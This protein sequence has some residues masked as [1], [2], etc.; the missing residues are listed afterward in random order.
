VKV[1]PD[2]DRARTFPVAEDFAKLHNL[3]HRYLMKVEGYGFDQK[4]A[5]HY[6]VCEFIDG[7]PLSQMVREKG[8]EHTK[9]LRWMEQLAEALEYLHAQDLIHFDVKP[10]NV[11]VNRR[12]LVLVDF[13]VAAHRD[14]VWENWR[15]GT[16]LYMSPEHRELF[17]GKQKPD[18][19]S[20]VWS[21]GVIMYQLL[22]GRLP[23]K[24]ED[25]IGNTAPT[26]VEELK[27][28]VPAPV[29]KI[30][31]GCL[32]RDVE[33][34][35]T[36][37][38]LR[39]AISKRLRPKQILMV[40][41]WTT[42]FT[43][44]LA[45]LSWGFVYWYWV[46]P[47]EERTVDGLPATIKNRQWLVFQ[48]SPDQPVDVTDTV[49]INPGGRLR[50]KGHGKLR[51][52]RGA[53]IH[54]QG[55][56]ELE[57][58]SKEAPLLFQRLNPQEEWAGVRLVGEHAAGSSLRNARFE[59]GGGVLCNVGD[60]RLAGRPN[61]PQISFPESPDERT[62]SH[63]GALLI[64]QTYDIQL[65]GVHFTQN[66]ARR[67]GAVFILDAQQIN[68]LDCHFVGNETEI[69]LEPTK[70]TGPPAGGAVF[71]Q[72]VEAVQFTQC[73]F[74][75]NRSPSR[76]ACG[77]A[78][79][80][81]YR[82]D[83]G[84]RACEF[85]RNQSGHVGGA[86]YLAAIKPPSAKPVNR[87]DY[88]GPLTGCVVKEQ[89][90]FQ[91]NLAGYW[92][93]SER[94]RRPVEFGR[95]KAIYVEHG[96]ELRLMHS[97][98]IQTVLN[99]P[100]VAVDG[101]PTN[102]SRFTMHDCQFQ[103]G[104]EGATLEDVCVTPNKGKHD[105]ITITP[106][107]THVLPSDPVRE[108]RLKRGFKESRWRRA[109]DTVVVHHA[110]ALYWDRDDPV[111]GFNAAYRELFFRDH[112]G[113]DRVRGRE[114]DYHPKFVKAILEVYNAG[115]HFLIARDGQISRLTAEND[116]A[117]HAG[118][119]R[120]PKRFDPKQRE[121]VNLFSIGIELIAVHP[122]NDDRVSP[123][124]GLRPFAD[125]KEPAYTYAQYE[126]LRWLLRD[127]A[128]RGIPITAVV[129]HDEITQFPIR[130]TPRRDPGRHFNWANVRDGNGRPLP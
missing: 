67:G 122:R 49:R 4:T 42:L 78:V 41:A 60:P 116:V 46:L 59:G 107:S 65:V 57:G 31:R 51:F 50:I 29:K 123:Q 113:L 58:A 106:G 44:A 117:F 100:L 76:H 11:I 99:E 43:L 54:A 24:K 53:G 13:G 126:A 77:G 38:Q 81:G 10:D 35:Y 118:V 83:L 47:P 124:V 127:F 9:V 34:R 108:D 6:L 92:H 55:V 119:S 22:T 68:F 105:A 87:D 128:R 115:P 72:V 37:R 71:T 3:K 45:L 2:S 75:E 91:D 82:S 28:N 73:Q 98:F 32:E 1:I 14:A 17:R 103:V 96:V 101:A 94:Q 62:R 40:G 70:G 86:L 79:Y 74:V 93:P 26:P 56:L 95:G 27:P 15:G 120:M 39:K 85:I 16:G 110:S 129:G 8:L 84:F 30:L 19:R 7:S 33:K 89:C 112:P 90:L 125:G 88:P 97:A 130:K 111:K 23:F 5:C 48:V 12:R 114:R 36:A 121:D 25:L 102:P 52:A 20:D 66:R 21:V 63:G 104:R 80:G 18:G 61:Q 69:E 64:G 109:I